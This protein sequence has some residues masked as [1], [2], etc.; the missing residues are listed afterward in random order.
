MKEETPTPYNILNALL[1]S[2]LI[3]ICTSSLASGAMAFFLQQYPELWPLMSKNDGQNMNIAGGVSLVFAEC[4]VCFWYGFC[5]YPAGIRHFGKWHSSPRE[6]EQTR[7]DTL[8][9][10]R[11]MEDI[12][13]VC[14]HYLHD[15]KAERFNPSIV[16]FCFPVVL[17]EQLATCFAGSIATAACYW[18]R[19]EETRSFGKN[20]SKAI[21]GLVVGVGYYLLWIYGNTYCKLA[22]TASL[23][24]TQKLYNAF[25]FEKGIA[26]F[27]QS[28][29][30]GE[31]ILL[32]LQEK[33]K[34]FHRQVDD[35]D[36]KDRT[37]SMDDDHQSGEGSGNPNELPDFESLEQNE[38]NKSNQGQSEEAV[39]TSSDAVLYAKDTSDKFPSKT[40]SL[41]PF[42]PFSMLKSATFPKKRKTS[43][44]TILR[45]N[46][47]DNV[48]LNLSYMDSGKIEM[49]VGSS[50]GNDD[51]KKDESAD[52]NTDPRNDKYDDSFRTEAYNAEAILHDLADGE[53]SKIEDVFDSTLALS[54]F[55]ATKRRLEEAFYSSTRIQVKANTNTDDNHDCYS[56]DT[57]GPQGHEIRSN[58][59]YDF[60][61]ENDQESEVPRILRVFDVDH[62]TLDEDAEEVEVDNNGQILGEPPSEDAPSSGKEG[63]PLYAGLSRK[64]KRRLGK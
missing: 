53:S 44:P 51:D 20:L 6:R 18:N 1:Q 61:I 57:I 43:A 28:V 4:I 19:D 25:L 36:A 33:P 37:L 10:D 58:D 24:L 26:E 50:A 34:R 16:W 22:G 46:E 47:N 35:K 12:R 38:A 21:A 7:Q 41:N 55:K 62:E 2:I 64:M 9:G 49:I 48:S 54:V 45:D 59:S 56:N 14:S 8:V 3:V 5:R 11:D 29:F 13:A 40:R 31:I 30:F 63:S 23:L 52:G 17:V 39:A 32:T 27:F 15:E 60:T 42:N